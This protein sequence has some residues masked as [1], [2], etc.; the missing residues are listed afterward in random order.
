MIQSLINLFTFGGNSTLLFGSASSPSISTT[1]SDEILQTVLSEDSPST[2][3]STS[4]TVTS[5]S[6][7]LINSAS[8]MDIETQVEDTQMIIE[9]MSIEELS[10]LKELIIEKGSSLTLHKD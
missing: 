7:A 4:L 6:S 9:S 3:T 10:E 1:F 8:A 5:V 2:S